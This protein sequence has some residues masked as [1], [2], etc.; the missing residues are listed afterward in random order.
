[1]VAG[2]L[3][4]LFAGKAEEFAEWVLASI[5]LGLHPFDRIALSADLE[6][7]AD[8]VRGVERRC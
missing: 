7:I 8:S 1:M 2:R 5:P 3:R 6:E 4:D